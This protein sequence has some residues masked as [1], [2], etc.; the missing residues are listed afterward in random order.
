MNRDDCL[1]NAEELINGPRAAYYGDPW[2]MH[3][4]VAD[5]W[6][7]YLDLKDGFR[8]SVKDVVCMMMLL[9]IARLR[10][11]VSHD[12]FI[13]ICGYAALGAEMTED[14]TDV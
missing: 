11:A 14:Q 5:L 7:D 3:Q 2:R 6:S 12:S 8:F 4:R 13:D 9:K 10:H 1:H